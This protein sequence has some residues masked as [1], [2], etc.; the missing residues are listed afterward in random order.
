MLTYFTY[1]LCSNVDATRRF[2]GELIGLKT[3]W[4]EADD[5]TFVHDGVQ[6]S[7]GLGPVDIPGGWAFQP[8]WALGQ[9]D[10]APETVK[11]PSASIALPAEEF[12]HAVARLREAGVTTLRDEPF[13]VGY[14]S[15]VVRDPDGRTVELSDPHTAGP[16]GTQD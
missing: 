6:I 1:D 8:G 15:F 7:F 13:W 12:N 11:A 4:H 16:E 10:S 5:V 3:V 9:L 14:W 2:Y